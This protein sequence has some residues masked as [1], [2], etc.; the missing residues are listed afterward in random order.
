MQCN[1]GE[2]ESPRTHLLQN[3]RK[4]PLTLTLSPQESL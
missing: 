2:G 1:P 4:Q 3:L